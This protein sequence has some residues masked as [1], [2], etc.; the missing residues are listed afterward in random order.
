[1]AEYAEAVIEALGAKQLKQEPEPLVE[2]E[3]LGEDPIRGR[4]L[5]V[6][7]RE[8]IANEY[9]RQIDHMAETLAKVDGITGVIREDRE[10]LLVATPSW[11][12]AQLQEGVTRALKTPE[13]TNHKTPGSFR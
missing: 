12:I 8:D 10:V 9:S 1:M 5:E 7:L 6:S 11:D 2:I 3:D 13:T 4:E